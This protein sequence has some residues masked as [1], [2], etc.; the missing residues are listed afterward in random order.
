MFSLVRNI[1][2]ILKLRDD[3]DSALDIFNGIRVLAMCWV[4]YSHEYNSRLRVVTN[5]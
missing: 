4:I 3:G 1:K 5:L 2:S